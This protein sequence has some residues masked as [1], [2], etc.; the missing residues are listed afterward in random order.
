MKI[1]NIKNYSKICT[2]PIFLQEAVIYF[3]LFQKRSVKKSVQ[4]IDF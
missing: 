3:L 2:Q 4:N 1:E